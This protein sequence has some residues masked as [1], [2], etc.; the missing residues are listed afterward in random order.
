MSEKVFI[1][2]PVENLERSKEFFTQLGYSFNPQFTDENAA[3]MVI[4]ES[5]FAMLLVKPFFA[6]FIDRPISDAN[7]SVEVLVALMFD[8]RADVDERV[9]RAIAAGGR[10]YRPPVDHGFMYMRS[11]SDLDGHCWE[12]GWMDP[13]V[14]QG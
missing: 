13:S 12:I 7:A 10:E 9:D 6:T 2:L 1:N 11:F 3:C 8:S 4:S 5:I 14:V